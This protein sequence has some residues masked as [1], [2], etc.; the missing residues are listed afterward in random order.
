MKKNSLVC[1]GESRTPSDD[2]QTDPLD[3][4]QGNGMQG[5]FHWANKGHCSV[6]ALISVAW[7]VGLDARSSHQWR[8][9]CRVCSRKLAVYFKAELFLLL[10]LSR[11]RLPRQSSETLCL[12]MRLG[13]YEIMQST[14]PICKAETLFFC[15]CVLNGTATPNLSLSLFLSLSLTL[16][17]SIP[18]SLSLSRSLSLSHTHT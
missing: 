3:S 9:V 1:A 4:L 17:L 18:Q 14:K 2:L 13:D 10:C 11:S 7:T 12:C 8:G 6:E 15:L 5:A 16:A